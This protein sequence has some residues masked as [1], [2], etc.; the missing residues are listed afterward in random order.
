[1]LVL[2][3]VLVVSEIVG[4]NVRQSP[5]KKDG[6]LTTELADKY[7][8]GKELFSKYCNKCHMA[9]DKKATDQWLFENLFN[10]LP[11][12][13]VIKYINNSRKLKLSGDKYAIA[14]AE[15]YNSTY[16]HLFKDSLSDIEFDNLIIY[17]KAATH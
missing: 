9:P 15:A 11:S 7:N 4:C 17:M 16:D 1:M 6:T 2:A 13:Y 12:D 10:R 14:V 3:T 8:E 5:D